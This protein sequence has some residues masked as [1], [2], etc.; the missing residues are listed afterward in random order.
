[1][2]T[3]WDERFREKLAGQTSLNS[4]ALL[5]AESAAELGWDLAAFQLDREQLALPRCSD[6]QFIG[7]AMGWPS[8]C[9]HAWVERELGR[10]CPVTQMCG[11]TADAIVWEC[12]PA[13][14]AWRGR[15]LTAEQV[16][17]LGY[18]RNY[19]EGAVTVPVH[20]PGGKSGYVTWCMADRDRLL[21]RAHET[22]GATYLISHAFIRHIDRLDAL[23]RD[24]FNMAN[25]DALTAREIECLNWAACGKTEEEVALIIHRSHETAR[26]HLRN[27]VT[28]LNASNRTHAVA[29]AC[30]RG[31]ITVR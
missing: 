27:A 21:Q 16:E 13:G 9:V 15:K 11:R 20:R 6:G 25:P 28:K 26:F 10:K 4:A 2:E 5:L 12:D 30:S 23:R 29:I 14:V 1:M 3:T 22:Y 7:T 24:A 19:F 8:D 31:L 17:V 18:Y